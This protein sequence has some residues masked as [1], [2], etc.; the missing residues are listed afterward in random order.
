MAKK[1]KKLFLA[2]GKNTGEGVEKPKKRVVAKNL[3]GNY[4]EW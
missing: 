3:H 2:N 1:N 4:S